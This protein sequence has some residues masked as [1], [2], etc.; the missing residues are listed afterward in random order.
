MISDDETV[1]Q[2]NFAENPFAFHRLLRIV[3]L[4]HQALGPYDPF[5]D[6]CF[7][8]VDI[9][10]RA[11]ESVSGVMTRCHGRQDELRD[12]AAVPNREGDIVRGIGT[13]WSFHFPRPKDDTWISEHIINPLR[14]LE[15]EDSFDM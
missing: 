12:P 3:H 14:R 10:M 11:V 13:S 15:G 9:I 1:A 6:N 2:M 8:F 7:T 4:T 5:V